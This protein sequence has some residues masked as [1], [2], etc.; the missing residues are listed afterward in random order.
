MNA[1]LPVLRQNQ[2]INC[3]A[4]FLLMMEAQIRLGLSTV[5]VTSADIG[6]LSAGAISAVWPMRPQPHA[7]RTR[8]L[9]QRQIDI[10]AGNGL[11]LVEVRRCGRGPGR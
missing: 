1:P 4:N 3:L 9:V 5:A 6:F 2:A 8:R 11:Q 7:F 10:E